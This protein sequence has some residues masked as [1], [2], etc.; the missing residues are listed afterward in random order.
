MLNKL[1]NTWLP[2]QVL[3][4]RMWAR[5]AFYQNGGAFGFRD[6]LQ[7]SM[8]AAEFMPTEAKRQILNCCASQFTE[9]DVLHWWHRTAYGRRGVR[10]TCSDDLLW[11][12]CVT[13]YYVRKTGDRNILKLNVQYIKGED[14]NGAHEKYMEVN[15]TD[16]RENVYLHC[17]KALEKGF[18]TGDKGLIPIAGGDWN[19]GYNRVGAGGRGES[20][21]LS[22]FYVLTVKEFAP[23]AREMHE[24]KYAE[25]LEKRAAQLTCAITENGWE[26]GYFLRAF[27]DDGTKMGGKDSEC[28]KID[29]LPQAFSVLADIPDEEKK[30]SALSNAYR[31]LVSEQSGI[32]KL[33]SPPFSE[34]STD[35]PGYVKSYP[36]GIREN[37]GQYTHA[38][39]WAVWGLLSVG[40]HEKAYEML[41]DINPISRSLEISSALRYKT[42][43]YALCGDVYSNP[44][45][46][47]RGGWSLYTGSASWFVRIVINELLGY[48]RDSAGTIM[49]PEYVR[50]VAGMTVEE[51]LSFF[52]N[53]PK[54]AKKG[55]IV[56]VVF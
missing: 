13:A 9:G 24:D 15:G 31:Q 56:Y 14:L 26:N 43:P 1:Y 2:W 8:A 36:M 7:D 28:C 30:K 38:A 4:C 12:P 39:T 37:G 34:D 55:K 45:H 22:M 3:G 54:I 17:K 11:L 19:D 16:V 47:G 52:A 46:L 40:E 27:Y 23:L 41:S 44:Q 10:T 48:P 42:E 21:W 32:I 5:T 35:D 25:E 53:H 33:F 50:L 49:T 20:V 29:L 6:Q 51:A 18:K